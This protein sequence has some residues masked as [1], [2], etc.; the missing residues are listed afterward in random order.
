[1]KT[2]TSN[3]PTGD[4]SGTRIQR[5][6]KLCAIGLG[7]AWLGS[8]PVHAQ[9]TTNAYD[10]ATNSVYTGFSSGLN[11]GFGF[12]PW[13]VAGSSGG[14]YVQGSTP[15]PI[16]SGKAWAIWLDNAS[17]TNTAQRTFNTPLAAGKTF[18][19]TRQVNNLAGTNFAAVLLQDT[20]GNTLFKFW[21]KGGDNA[22]GH[23]ADATTNNG[24]ATGFPFAFQGYRSYSFK[25]T[26]S[27]N[28]VFRNITDNKSFTGTITGSVARVVFL[29]QNGVASGGGADYR[30][31]SLTISS[32]PVTFQ[33]QVPAINSY[34][35]IRT[36]ISV[37]AL[38][39]GN[40][41]NTNT[42]VMKVDGSTVSPSIATAAGVTTISYTPGVPFGAGTTHTAFVTLA[43]SVGN[44]F[45]NTWSFTTGHPTLPVTMPEPITVAYATNGDVGL[46]LFTAAGE[47]WL[48]TNYGTTSTQTLYLRYSMVFNNLNAETGT[49][50]GYGGLHLMADGAEKLIVG[51]AWASTNWSLDVAGNQQDLTPPT[52]P[53]V[54]SEWHTIVERID[55]VP[56]APDNVKVWFDPDFSKTESGQ[57]NVYSIAGDVSFNNAR[58]RCGNGTASATW[59]NI[60]VGAATTDVGFPPGVNPTITGLPTATGIIFGQ[61]LA[62]STLSGGSATNIAGA[63]DVPGAFTFTNPSQYANAGT[64]TVNVTFVPTDLG[65]YNTVVTNI[66]IAVDKNTPNLLLAGGSAILGQ[67]LSAANLIFAA[68][69]SFNNA[70]AAGSFTINTP[71]STVPNTLGTITVNVTFT[72]ADPASYNPVTA[73]VTVPVNNGSVTIYGSS[74]AKGNGSSG[75]AANVYITGGSASNS[76]AAL[77]TTNLLASS[78]GVTNVSQ[79]GDTSPGGVSRF[80]SAVIPTAP[81]YVLISYSLGNDNLGNNTLDPVATVSTFLANLTNMVSQ[82]FS[83]GYQPVVALCY[84]RNDIQNANR[85]PYMQ[86]ANLVINS[87]NVPSINLD[88]VLNNDSGGLIGGLNSGDGIHPNDYGHAEIYYS[89]PPTIFDAL[90]QGKTNRPGL[91][92]ATNFARLTALP[93]VTAPV[94]FTP[95]NTVHSY[96]LTFKVRAVSGGTIATI[97]TGTGFA[98]L[99]ITNGRFAYYGTNGGSITASSINA[100]NGDWHEVAISHRYAMTNTWLF[101]DGVQAGTLSEQYA[102]SQFVVGGPGNSA[103]PVAPA[104]MDLK[105][106]YVYRAAWNLA[107]AQAQAQGRLQVAS[108]EI[109]SPLDDTTFTS[110]SPAINQAASLSGVIINTDGLAPLQSVAPPSNLTAA[111]LSATSARLAWTRNSTSEDG[112]IIERRANGGTTWSI[113][114]TVSAGTTNY[115]DAG[116]TLGNYYDYRVAAMEAG[117]A[118]NYSNVATVG[119]GVGTHAVVLVDFGPNDMANGQTTASPD[120]LEQYWNNVISTNLGGSISPTK[121]LSNMVTTANSTTSIGLVASGNWSANGIQSGGLLA[122]SYALLGNFAVPTA[123]EDYFFTGNSASLAVTNLDPAYNYT[124]RLFA[125]RNAASDRIGKYV[126]TGGNGSFTNI[127]QSSSVTALWTNN[128]VPY[129]GNNNTILKVANVTPDGANRIQVAVSTNSVD[130]FAYVAILEITANRSPVAQPIS[131]NTTVGQSVSIDVINGGNAPTDADG[132]ALVVT[133]VSLIAGGGSVTTNGGTGFNYLATTPGTNQFNY[134]VRDVYGGTGTN[135]VTVVVDRITPTVTWPVAT[136]ITYGQALAASTLTGGAATN[137]AD[138]SPVTGSFAFAL[139]ALVPFAGTTNVAVTFT[140]DNPTNF[141]G[142]NTLVGVTVDPAMLSITANSLSKP[143]GQ[144][145]TFAGTE[146][147][148]SGL[149]NGDSVTSVMLTSAGAASTAP[150]GSYAIVPSAAVGSGL[151]NYAISYT[152]GTLTVTG[153]PQSSFTGI[154]ADPG[155]SKT[156]TFSGSEGVTYRIQTT[157]D[158]ANPSWTDIATNTVGVSGVSSFTDTNAIGQAKFYRIVCP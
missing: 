14:A 41:V 143:Y 30:F 105:D 6:L 86:G 115:D 154:V 128:G 43:D 61:A 28:Y 45:T 7:S 130:A 90:T 44:L 95:S 32:D 37:Q 114:A 33:S 60:V 118:G 138:N 155:G 157:T 131:T 151:N 51:N 40:S 34:S 135:T 142:A 152:N 110:N 137:A 156:I 70:S 63:T 85:Y 136:A 109:A 57:T 126:V 149:V 99:Q 24:V 82:C 124:L 98:T 9:I 21:H 39:G 132:D 87:W 127:L 13:T 5:L 35:G 104:V 8:L 103:A 84:A 79:P 133:S 106:L 1:M 22:D 47:D 29:R 73:D 55:F 54:F 140:P 16:T 25:L 107:E 67:P 75:S 72:P 101:V 148:P 102:P 56:G 78:Y 10:A 26:T 65:I 38:D 96:T 23:Y 80:A 66:T 88:G 62:T 125:T 48:G 89:I 111:T 81:N 122:P 93:G 18:S 59:S 20:N 74:V 19:F 117:L 145:V 97:P 100:T 77:L 58:L 112:F 113:V 91:A 4:T 116:L 64:P 147:A 46:T 27:S 83:N 153:S 12:G 11:G 36:N 123:T 50:G 31:D 2:T 49:G 144:T 129:N 121:T 92:A 71:L 141:N 146:F 119:V 94:V 158:L 52:R 76:W 42:I 15:T 69:N 150:A 139:P 17:N 3:H 134:V 53:V 108:L 68:A 120:S